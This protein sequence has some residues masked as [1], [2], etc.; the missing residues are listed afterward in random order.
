M[1]SYDVI[2]LGA[3]PAGS[4][5]AYLLATEGLSV[6]VADRSDGPTFKVGESLL[7]EGVRLCH[8]MGLA[9]ALVD[10]PFQPKHGAQFVLSA[11]DHV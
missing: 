10:G 3:G 6:V 1:E 4:T 5:L 7:P 2:I 8:E 9:A 11:D